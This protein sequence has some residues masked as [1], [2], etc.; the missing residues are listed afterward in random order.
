MLYGAPGLMGGVS[1]FFPAA[2]QLVLAFNCLFAHVQ[3]AAFRNPGI[4]GWLGL[5][6]LPPPGRPAPTATPSVGI[7]NY[8]GS[9]RFQNEKAAEEA[10]AK[11][12]RYVPQ[13]MRDTYKEIMASASGVSKKASDILTARQERARRENEARRAKEYDDKRRREIEIEK[14][15]RGL[16]KKRKKLE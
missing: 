14:A 7:M 4:R 11:A 16:M 5:Q 8:Q 15:A 6:P 9:T 2:L 12:P 10:P 13:S 3:S 1:I